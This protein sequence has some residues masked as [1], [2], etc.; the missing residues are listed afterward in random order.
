MSPETPQTPPTPKALYWIGVALSVLC[1]LA[2]VGSGIMK[3][4]PPEGFDVEFGKLG[5][6]IEK[7]TTLAIIEFACALLYAIPRT[8]V[9]GAIL[10]TGY[11]G[12][13]VATH[14]R[15]GDG[16][17]FSPVIFGVVVWLGVFLRD[18]R[19]RALI[20]IRS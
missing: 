16:Q 6:T 17:F 12:G 18:A 20:P 3:L 14:V 1:T 19:L 2:L 13:A 15:I 10:A 7:A 11:L 4:R 8:S 9:L 5:W